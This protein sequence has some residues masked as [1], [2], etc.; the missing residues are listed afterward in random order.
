MSDAMTSLADR[1]PWGEGWPR[2]IMCGKGWL[3][4]IEEVHE[5]LLVIC[6]T[7]DLAQVK[8]K[9]GGLRYYIDTPWTLSHERTEQAHEVIAEAGARSFTICEECGQ[10]GKPVTERGWVR[11]VCPLHR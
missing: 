1:L 2:V 7:Y 3:P 9:F 6:G 5:K 10:P 11:T 4:L 8:Q